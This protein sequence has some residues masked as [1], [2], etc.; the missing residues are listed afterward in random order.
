MFA[1]IRHWFNPFQTGHHNYVGAIQT[2]TVLKKRVFLLNLTS[3]SLPKHNKLTE[4]EK[5]L[6]T[7]FIAEDVLSTQRTMKKTFCNNM[8]QKQKKMR[9]NEAVPLLLAFQKKPQMNFQK[10]GY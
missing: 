5:C 2:T 1:H 8:P 3:F 6:W 7:K 10:E 4:K 9:R